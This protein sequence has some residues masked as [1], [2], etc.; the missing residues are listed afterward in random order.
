MSLR[1]APRALLLIAV[2]GLLAYG[3]TLRNG[4]VWDDDSFLQHNPLVQ[5]PD[6]L[7]RFWTSAGQPDYWPVT[8]STFWVEWRLWGTHPAGY[9]ATELVLHVG[10]AMLLWLVLRR[11]GIPGATLAALLFVTHPVNVESVAWIAQRKNL[12]SMVFCLAAVYWFLRP[13]KASYGLSLLAFTLAMLSKGS[14]AMLPVVLLGTIAWS[15]RPTGRDARLL[16]PFFA[17]AAGLV[18]VNVWFEHRGFATV[19]RQVTVPERIAGAGAVVWFYLGKAIAPLG[20][21]FV[22]PQWKIDAGSWLWWIPLAGVVAV[23][24]LLIR[25]GRGSPGLARGCLFAWLYFCVMLVP[26]MGLTDVY[27]MRYTLVADHYEQL[28]LLG[29][30]ALAGAAW[31]AWP[32]DRRIRIAAAG[33]TLALFIALTW[34]Q[35]ATYRDAETLYQATLARNPNAWMVDNS[36]GLLRQQAGKMA[37]A[38]A[39]YEQ[40]IRINPDFAEAHLNLGVVEM[41]AGET[42]AAEAEFR[43]SLALDPGSAKAHLNLGVV[44]ISEGRPADAVSEIK[45]A[46]A[47]LPDYPEAYYNL[48]NALQSLGRDEEAAEAFSAGLRLN[49]NDAESET[50]L[51]TALVRLGRVAEAQSHFER[52]IRIDPGDAEAHCELGKALDRQ[53]RPAEGIAE[54]EAALRARPDYPDAEFQLGVSLG[55]AG[56][57]DEAAFHLRRAIALNPGSYSAHNALG[58]MLA[59]AGRIAEAEAEFEAALRIRPDYGP[60]RDN[61]EQIRGMR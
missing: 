49:P 15:R 57:L 40:A 48:G 39:Y 33:A 19:I 51:G 21:T 22:Y 6:G 7:A 47:I 36:L 13:G 27:Y 5:A 38:R 41:A 29:A 8:L 60:A 10:S 55:N 16:A 26:V 11:L 59:Q 18:V 44:E 23:T 42:G 54:F 4:F 30:T 9:H 52:A 20:L 56:R 45:R 32:A 31:A 2:V 12:V 46:I 53:G 35:A 1:A 14:V 28:A 50:Y 58:A 34:R 3:P 24:A 17:V 61:L 37:E 43:R 25:A